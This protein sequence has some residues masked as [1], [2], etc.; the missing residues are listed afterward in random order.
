MI[1]FTPETETRGG[2]S[3]DTWQLKL[4]PVPVGITTRPNFGCDTS[5]QKLRPVLIS[6]ATRRFGK[7]RLVAVGKAVGREEFFTY[8]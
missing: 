3:C 2:W 5:R 4:R 1:T 8:I 6:A 7:R